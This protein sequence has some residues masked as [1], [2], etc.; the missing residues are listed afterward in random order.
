MKRIYLTSAL[1]FAALTGIFAGEYNSVVVTEISY[2]NQTGSMYPQ[3]VFPTGFG[4]NSDAVKNIKPEVEALCEQRFGVHDIKFSVSHIIYRYGM[5]RQRTKP[6]LV[7]RDGELSVNIEMNLQ[8]RTQ[9]SWQHKFKLI[10]RVTASDSKGHEIYYFKNVIPFEIKESENVTG[11]L[12]LSDDQLSYLF[13]KGIKNAFKGSPKRSAVESFEQPSADYHNAFM[14]TSI[15]HYL[16]KSGRDYN[17]GQDPEKT[18]TV[19]KIRSNFGKSMDLGVDAGPLYRKDKIRDS[20]TIQ[21]HYN[22]KSY[23]QKVVG[24]TSELFDFITMTGNVTVVLNTGNDDPDSL[25]LFADKHMEGKIGENS[26][27]IS[28]L[29]QYKVLELYR[30]DSLF[31]VVKDLH[32]YEVIYVSPLSGP[33]LTGDML[34]LVCAY[35]HALMAFQ[36]IERKQEEDD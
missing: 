20:Y 19:L 33:G 31:A 11:I 12:L 17:L 21:N 28:Y 15:K 8:C 10:T 30:N 9:A 35:D 25:K 32:T 22:K 26:Y 5:F 7:I 36:E 6:L 13:Q 23:V 34:D 4:S 16:V 3:D 14:N 18:N 1:L 2:L 29:P 24:Q 27:S